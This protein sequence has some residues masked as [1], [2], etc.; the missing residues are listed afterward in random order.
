VVG[1][2][3][4]LGDDGEL[5]LDLDYGDDDPSACLKIWQVKAWPSTQTHMAEMTGT[6]VSTGTIRPNYPQNQ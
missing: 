2:W 3:E 6:T 5:E 4:T 1:D